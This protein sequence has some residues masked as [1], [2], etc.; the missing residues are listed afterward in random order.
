MS[1]II[2]TQTCYGGKN[3]TSDDVPGIAPG[4]WETVHCYK[5]LALVIT[6]TQYLLHSEYFWNLIRCLVAWLSSGLSSSEIPTSY[7]PLLPAI[8]AASHTEDKRKGNPKALSTYCGPVAT[9]GVFLFL[10]RKA[11]H[12][13]SLLLVPRCFRRGSSF[14]AGSAFA[15]SLS[16]P[17][18]EL[19]A[20]ISDS[21]P[22]LSLLHHRAPSSGDVEE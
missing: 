5:N 3:Q 4:A 21:Q 8:W 2:L 14:E 7:S 13:V 6:I 22:M 19:G 1:L 18:L 17:G 16:F 15:L 10:L 20:S 11:H 12:S 9:L